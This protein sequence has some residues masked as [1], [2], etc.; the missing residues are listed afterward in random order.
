MCFIEK[1][2]GKTQEVV[3]GEKIAWEPKQTCCAL[4]EFANIE[5]DD[6]I[7]FDWMNHEN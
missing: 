2:E 4:W 6:G 3:C 7:I 1:H 5:Y